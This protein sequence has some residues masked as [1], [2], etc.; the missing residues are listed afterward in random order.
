MK[1][2]RSVKRR[3]F[4][5]TQSGSASVAIAIVVMLLLAGAML[6]SFKVSGALVQDSVMS[7]QQ[8]QA[9]FVAESG[10]SH[11]LQQWGT[12]S[13]PAAPPYCANYGTK[14]PFNFGPGKFTISY[15]N[16]DVFGVVMTDQ[17]ALC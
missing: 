11:A 10:I 6:T 4:R 14:G 7:L 9:L 5:R 16:T 8:T 17:K 1:A 3:L 15:F 2:A 12:Y 13:G